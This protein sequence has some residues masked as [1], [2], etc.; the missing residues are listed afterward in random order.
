[1]ERIFKDFRTIQR[2]KS[3]PFGLYVQQLAER[4][5]QQ[6]YTREQAHKHLYTAD[7]FGRWLRR[8]HI[9]LCDVTFAHARRYL[10]A[11]RRWKKHGD[12]VALKRLFEMLAQEGVGQPLNALE[13]Q[14]E[15]VVQKFG[16]HLSDERALA[17]RTINNRKTVVKSFL[18]QKFGRRSFKCS[19]IKAEDLIGFVQTEAARRRNSIKT[20]ET[21]L[22][23]FTRYLLFTGRLKRNL[24]IAIPSAPNRRLIGIPRYLTAD[25]VNRVLASCNEQTRTGRRDYAILLLLARL[26]LRSGEVEALKLDDIDWITGALTVHGKGGKVRPMPLLHD[27]GTAISTYLRKDRQPSPDRRIFQHVAAPH[28]GLN[29]NVGHIVRFALERSGVQSASKGSHQFRHTIGSQMLANGASLAEIGEV[30]RHESPDTTFIYAKVDL[31]SLQSLAR[32][33]PGG[34]R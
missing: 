26:G 18:A 24:S 10:H 6:G 8:R 32:P 34:A 7:D 5:R 29:R 12:L 20:V 16:D 33:W 25:Q 27:V 3:G 13:S 31:R 1:M 28:V 9:A 30:L 19:A 4:L 17:R 11:D 15:L 2:Y 21:A 14:A 22:R 23:S